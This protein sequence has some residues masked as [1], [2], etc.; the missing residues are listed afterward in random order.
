[1]KKLIIFCSIG[2]I[3]AGFVFIVFQFVQNYQN[4]YD[5]RRLPD[6][7]IEAPK[8][9]T[10]I[11]SP[12]M[13]RGRAKGSWFFEAVFPIA[14]I[15]REGKEIA[16]SQA[17][18][19]GEWTTEKFVPFSAEIIFPTQDKG[20]QGALIFKRDNPSGLPENDASVSIP[21]TF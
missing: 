21:I 7:V 19:E 1:M 5:S 2:L 6:V 13:I 12:V 10:R 4:E 11:Q 17:R 15:N 16:T 18:A 20:E 3:I 8:I 9:N 14:L